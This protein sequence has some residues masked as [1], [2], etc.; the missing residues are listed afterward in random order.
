MYRYLI[1]SSSAM[2]HH[3]PIRI[4]EKFKLWCL[5]VYIYIPHKE[6]TCS[7]L[8]WLD[9]MEVNLEKLM[10]YSYILYIYFLSSSSL[11]DWYQ[12][13]WQYRWS[14]ELATHTAVRVSKLSRFASVFL[15]ADVFCL[16]TLNKWKLT[17]TIDLSMRMIYFWIIACSSAAGR[18]SSIRGR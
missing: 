6:L 15:K 12:V 2:F 1:K 4:R 8:I 16:S 3:V 7:F 17:H 11:L 14:R 13:V 10:V 5:N 18:P 9:R